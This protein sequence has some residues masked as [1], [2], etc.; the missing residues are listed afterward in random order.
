MSLTTNS[1]YNNN[2]LLASIKSTMPDARPKRTLVYVYIR[3][4]LYPME[5]CYVTE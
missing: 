1:H 2:D 4:G 3:V 5:T